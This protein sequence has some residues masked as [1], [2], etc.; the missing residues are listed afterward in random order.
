MDY[1]K[2]WDDWAIRYDLLHFSESSSYNKIA[3]NICLGLHEGDSVLEV[4]C[5]TGLLSE[6]VIKKSKV[7]INYIATDF[8][9][10]M[11]SLAQKK[12]IDAEFLVMDARDLTFKSGSFDTI[13]ISNALHIVPD[14]NKVLSEIN[15]VLK[16][17][18]AL[19]VSNFLVPT[20]LVEQIAV[21]VFK[22]LGYRV[23]NKLDL[24]T[25][26]ELINNSGFTITK[27]ELYHSLR[28]AIYLQCEKGKQKVL[29]NEI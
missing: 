2:F 11:I 26:I 18:G 10:K 27:K 15:R 22:I 14:A 1:K 9:E 16:D 8:S 24:D 28:T 25:C 29:T 7:K 6:K 13:I 17:N 12:K 20:T 19:F 21:S 4:A 5:G 3:D 23:F